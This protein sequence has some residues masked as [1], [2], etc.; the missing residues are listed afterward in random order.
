MKIILADDHTI[1]RKGLAKLINDEPDME[2][3]GEAG[4]GREALKL[5]QKHNPDMVIM[6]INMP[7]MNGVIATR[8]ISTE[9]PRIKVLALS[10]HSDAHFVASALKAGVAGYLLKDCAVKEMVCAVRDIMNGKHYLD[11]SLD[12]PEISAFMREG[13]DGGKKLH[14]L[15]SNREL[16]VLQLITEGKNTKEIALTL[17]LSIKTIESHRKHIMDKLN[18]HSI[19][20]LTKYAVREGLTS[21]TP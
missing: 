5:M 21:V 4:D 11:P 12:S 8:Q 17:F 2:V 9:F 14:A 19:A 7:E 16:Q 10:M 6:D 13:N 3:I 18:I 15:L 1:V 20:E